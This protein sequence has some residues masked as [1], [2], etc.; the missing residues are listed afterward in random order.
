MIAFS[1]SR[2]FS[3]IR[4]KSVVSFMYDSCFLA[5]GCKSESIKLEMRSVG[6][7]FPETIGLPAK[8]GLWILVSVENSGTYSEWILTIAEPL[9][10]RFVNAFVNI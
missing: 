2:M 1:G 10:S 5:T 8:F 3:M 6:P 4:A 9:E 7:P